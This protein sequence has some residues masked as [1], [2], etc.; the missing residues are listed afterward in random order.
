M[1]VVDY[2]KTT[3]KRAKKRLVVY[4]DALLHSRHIGTLNLAQ[5][6]IVLLFSSKCMKIFIIEIRKRIVKA[7]VQISIK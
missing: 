1:A 3:I 4:Y 7:S 5:N 2:D 6:A